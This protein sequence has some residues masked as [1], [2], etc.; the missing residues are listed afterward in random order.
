MSE[1]KL[2][3]GGMSCAHCTNRVKKAIDALEGVDTSAVEIG[4][5]VV[6]IDDARTTQKAVEQAVIDAGYKIL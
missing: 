5:A 3:I 6:K 4:R 1:I 2:T